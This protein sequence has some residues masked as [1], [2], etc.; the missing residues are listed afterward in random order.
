MFKEGQKIGM[1]WTLERVCGWS[2]DHCCVDAYS[3]RQNKDGFT[4]RANA[5]SEDVVAEQKDWEIYDATHSVLVEKGRALSL[6]EKLKVLENTKGCNVEI[7]FSGGDV[8]LVSENLSVVRKAS[9]ML[10]KENIGLT[11]T[12]LGMRSPNFTKYLPFIAQLEFTFDS[13]IPVDVNHNQTGYNRSNLSGFEKVIEVCRKNSVVTQALI[14]I[15][16]SNCGNKIVDEIYQTLIG[17]G[18]DRV[19]LMRTLPVGR[20]IKSNTPMLTLKRYKSAVERYWQLQAETDGPKVGI[21]CALKN[22]FPDK[23]GDKNP[24]TLLQSTLDITSL[25]DVILDAFGY[26]STGSALDKGFIV[27]NLTRTKLTDILDQEVVRQLGTRANENIG[28]C[29]IAAYLQNSEMGIEG[30][31]MKSDPLYTRKTK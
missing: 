15:S 21:M 13:I 23:F 2:C 20:A 24:C 9:E 3:T 30:L 11:V 10:G 16:P 22:I 8:P 4:I 17:S 19:Y 6:N 28:H 27:G 14:P 7:G 31:F 25:G 26:N 29:K 5:F 12:G 18:V 1:I